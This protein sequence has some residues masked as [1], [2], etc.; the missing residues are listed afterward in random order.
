MNEEQVIADTRAWVDKAVIGLN[1][2]P[3][4]KQV[5]VKG[6]VRYVVS[7]STSVEALLY[8][9]AAEL[10]HLHDTPAEQTDTTLLIHPGV[11]TD[12]LDYN[13]FLD[14]ADALVAEI[15]LEGELQIA[16]FHPQYQFEGTEV[17]DITNYSNRSPYPTL[18][19]IREDS[20]DRAVAAFPE[21][22]SIFEANM[23]TL[24][25]L[26]IE[27]WKKLGLKP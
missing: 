18:H 10:N 11:L 16:S 17:D 12:F 8:E 26:G 21:A 24:E 27:G 19:L 4:A 23:E 22:E 20:I 9:L 3:F 15:G 6:Q 1:L 7:S 14:A 2:C 5:Q 25:K 13:D